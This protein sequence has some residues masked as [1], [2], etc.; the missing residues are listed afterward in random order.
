MKGVVT[1][2]TITITLPIAKPPLPQ[3]FY[4]NRYGTRRKRALENDGRTNVVSFLF[5]YTELKFDIL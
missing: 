2:N 4:I 3:V 1:S 5:A